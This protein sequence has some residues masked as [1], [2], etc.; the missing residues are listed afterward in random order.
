MSARRSPQ[1]V[2]LLHC[3]AGVSGY[4][5]SCQ[6]IGAD[7]QERARSMIQI[8][9]PSQGSLGMTKTQASWSS[10][11]SASLF[12]AGVGVGVKKRTETR[13]CG[14]SRQY[15]PTG[16]GSRPEKKHGSGLRSVAVLICHVASPPKLE[17]QFSPSTFSQSLEGGAEE[18][19]TFLKSL[20]LPRMI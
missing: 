17:S 13:H 12:R 15:A 16:C 7:S 5:T 9:I 4:T 11:T 6:Y 10:S 3:G 1:H 2:K 8:R 14:K 18:P 20:S 19:T